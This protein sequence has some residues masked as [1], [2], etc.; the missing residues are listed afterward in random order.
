[1]QPH[2]KSAEKPKNC[3]KLINL[4]KKSQE[5]NFLGQKKNFWREKIFQNLDF[6][7]TLSRTIFD[8]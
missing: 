6:G 3:Q 5:N 8:M 7:K 4:P 2:K 1:M